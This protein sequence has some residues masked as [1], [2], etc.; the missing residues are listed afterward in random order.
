M[1]RT[2]IFIDTEF[3]D[4]LNFDLISIA[5]VSGVDTYYGER[6]DFDR[7]LCEDFTCE[8][9]LPQLGLAQPKTKAALTVEV[10]EWLWRYKD[11]DPVLSFDNVIDFGLLRELLGETP[12]WLHTQNIKDCLNREAWLNYF[13]VSNTQPHHALHDALAN[14]K[15]YESWLSNR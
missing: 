12:E 13:V 6:G 2:R 5:L 10:R 1:T 4:L 7:S 9:V 14:Q 8:N 11:K 3:T 15:A